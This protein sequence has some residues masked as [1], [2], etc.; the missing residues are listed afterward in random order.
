MK[1]QRHLESNAR[2]ERDLPFLAFRFS[3]RSLHDLPRRRPGAAHTTTAWGERDHGD[4]TR[5][6]C[7]Y[8]PRAMAELGRDLH[9]AGVLD[10]EDYALLAFQPELHP[11]FDRTVGALTG[12]RADP[13]RPRDYLGIWEDRLNFERSRTPVDSKLIDRISRILLLLR[14][15]GATPAMAA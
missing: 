10:N 2:R 8:S 13:D 1:Q 15:L 11:D 12:E 7:W 5:P 4:R 9:A 6:G 3:G 14:R